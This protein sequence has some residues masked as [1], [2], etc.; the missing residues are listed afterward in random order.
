MEEQVATG[1]YVYFSRRLRARVEQVRKAKADEARAAYAE[2]KAKA[3]PHPICK[4]ENME[5]VLAYLESRMWEAAAQGEDTVSVAILSVPLLHQRN[6]FLEANHPALA[7]PE[8]REVAQ[9]IVDKFKQGHPDFDARSHLD[10]NI[11]VMINSFLI[12]W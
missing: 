11:T 2:A 4:D 8:L 12:S 1:D 6:A 5:Q 9:F 10:A 3:G 7:K